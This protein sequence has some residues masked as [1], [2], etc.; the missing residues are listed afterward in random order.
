MKNV[1]LKLLLEILPITIHSE[2]LIALP[3][4]LHIVSVLAAATTATAA[5]TA[6][7]NAPAVTVA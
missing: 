4:I 5:A 7:G 6:S 1:R 2:N 3:M